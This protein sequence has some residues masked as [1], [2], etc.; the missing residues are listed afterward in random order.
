MGNI[1]YCGKPKKEDRPACPR[2]FELYREER[3]R[4]KEKPSLIAWVKMKALERLEE[5]GASQEDPRTILERDLEE[6]RKELQALEAVLPEEVSL[7]LR[8]QLAGAGRLRQDEMEA[9]REDIRAELWKQKGGNRLY[10]QVKDLQ[11]EV[12]EKIIPIRETLQEIEKTEREHSSV[13]QLLA[14]VLHPKEESK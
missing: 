7:T 9:L 14:S 8:E 10:A 3:K 11:R 13:D 12:K 4:K 1:C 2:C 5:L 6:K